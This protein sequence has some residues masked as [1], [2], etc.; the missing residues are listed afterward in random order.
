MS[1]AWRA[2]QK[3]LTVQGAERGHGTA[4]ADG[5]VP[6][7]AQT[8]HWTVCVRARLL[9]REF[10]MDM[11][12]RPNCGGQLKIIAAMPSETTLSSSANARSTYGFIRRLIKPAQP[13]LQRPPGA[14]L[15]R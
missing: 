10:E 6:R 2:G 15:T 9:K 14:W 1:A 5:P 13:A 3:V 8:V 11:E 7:Q 12:H 4:P